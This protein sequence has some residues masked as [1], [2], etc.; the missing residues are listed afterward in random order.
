MAAFGKMPISIKVKDVTETQS[1]NQQSTILFYK[2][3]IK[4]DLPHFINLKRRDVTSQLI[5]MFKLTTCQT[6]DTLF[7]ARIPGHVSERGAER[8]K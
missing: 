4:H 1:N 8:A 3:N 5:L 7:C 6:N 2:K